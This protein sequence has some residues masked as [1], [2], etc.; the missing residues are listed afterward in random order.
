MGLPLRFSSTQWSPPSRIAAALRAGLNGG[1][2]VRG[3]D[4]CTRATRT[5]GPRSLEAVENPRGNG[6]IRAKVR[7]TLKPSCAQRQATQGEILGDHPP[8]VGIQLARTSGN[9]SRSKALSVG[10]LALVNITSEPARGQIKGGLTSIGR[11]RSVRTGSSRAV[12][13]Q[14]VL[15]RRGVVPLGRGFGLSSPSMSAC[16]ANPTRPRMCWCS[17]V[18]VGCVCRDAVEQSPGG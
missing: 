8:P 1:V 10:V 18:L 11:A 5:R 6:V 13:G 4:A 9:R 12:R 17:P 2:A 14:W 15:L 16:A 3:V 7:T